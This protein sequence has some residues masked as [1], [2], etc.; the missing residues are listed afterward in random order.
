MTDAGNGKTMLEH[1][2][3]QE[4]LR[5]FVEHF[6]HRVLS[7]ELLSEMFTRAKPTHSAHLIAFFEEVMGGR[8][9]YTQ[10]HNGV[11]GLFD[12][13]ANLEITDAQRRRFVALMLE[14]A[15]AVGLPND[16]RFRSALARRIETGSMFSMTLSRPGAE[17]L[18]PWPPV[19]TYD[20]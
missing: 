15:D 5:A 3:G 11:E 10:R 1:I 6:H 2:G 8:K 12:A 13:H 9:I 18:W 14:A 7:D 19:G 16:E 20:W 17:R 4:P